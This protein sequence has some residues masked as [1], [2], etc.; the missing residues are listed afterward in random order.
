VTPNLPPIAQP[1]TSEDLR[2]RVLTL[3]ATLNGSGN[4]KAPKG[5]R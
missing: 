3:L 5:A 1:L 4:G 2:R